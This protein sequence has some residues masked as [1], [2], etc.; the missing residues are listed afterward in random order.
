MHDARGSRSKPLFIANAPEESSQD[1]Q[2]DGIAGHEYR[3][4]D[5]RANQVHP[6]DLVGSLGKRQ[7]LRRPADGRGWLD[8]D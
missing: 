2:G 8:A 5:G 4:P 7:P 3:D 1:Q 6:H